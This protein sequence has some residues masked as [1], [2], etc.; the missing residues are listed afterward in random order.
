MSSVKKI[1]KLFLGDNLEILKKILLNFKSKVKCIYIDP[2]Y[3]NGELYKHYDD[4]INDDWIADLKDRLY[5][6]RE[7]LTENGCLWISIDDNEMHYLKVA[8][9]KIFGRNNF[10]TTIVW[11]Q[12]TT[13]ENRKSF[14]NNHEYILV[15]SKN[16]KQFEKSVN[17]LEVSKDIIN[18]YK[19]LDNDSRGSWQSISINVQ[20]GHAVKSQFYKIKSPSG[21]IFEPPKGRCWAYNKKKLQKLIKEKRIWFGKNGDSAPRYKKFLSES[22]LGT[23]PETIWLGHEV[24]TNDEAKKEILAF[25]N[26]SIFDTPKPKRLIEKIFKISTNKGDLIM[27]A[28]AGSGT[29]MVVADEMNLQYIGIDNGKHFLDFTLKRLLKFKKR[30]SKEKIEIFETSRSGFVKKYRYV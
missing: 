26:S 15:Y 24:G 6:M 4:R 9:D 2:P 17:K 30:K 1:K 21:K 13:R 25:K 23:T 3:N 10:I 18:R 12:R 7:F 11:Q 22:K 5:I 20:A 19:N 29:S 28:Y 16:K 14:S 8:L 27:D